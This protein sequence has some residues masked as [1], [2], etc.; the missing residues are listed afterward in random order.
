MQRQVRLITISSKERTLETFMVREIKHLFVGGMGFKV[1]LIRREQNAVSHAL[2]WL[3][4]TSETT[5]VWLGSGRRLF[6]SYACPII[7]PMV[8]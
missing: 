1:E 7:T 4:R 3:G 5:A 8:N 6:N 2:A